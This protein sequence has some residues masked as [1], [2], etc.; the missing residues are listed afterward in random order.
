MFDGSDVY[1]RQEKE[2]DAAEYFS[3]ASQISM[4]TKNRFSILLEHLM[5]VADLKRCV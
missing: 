2:E 5:S 4:K 1:K 3:A